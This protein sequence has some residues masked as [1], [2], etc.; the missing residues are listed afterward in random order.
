MEFL[1]AQNILSSNLPEFLNFI[2]IF[3][4]EFLVIIIFLVI[5]VF[6]TMYAERKIYSLFVY[7][8]IPHKARFSDSL[9]IIANS[10]KLIFQ[11]AVIPDKADKTGFVLAPVIALAPV[12]FVWTIIP[13]NTDFCICKFDGGV[14]LFFTMLM[15][16]SFGVLLGGRASENKFSLISALRCCLQVI[17]YEIPVLLSVMS[18]VILSGTL[19][20]PQTVIAQAKYDIFSWYIFPSFFG[21]LI[22]VISGLALVSM[23]PFGFSKR[24]SNLYSGYLAEYSGIYYAVFNLAEYALLFIVCVYASTLFLG[25]FLSPFGIYVADFFSNNGLYYIIL[26]TEQIFWL[27]SKTIV[28]ILLIFW[29]KTA[30]PLLKPDILASFAWKYLIPLSVINLLIVAVIKLAFG[31]IYV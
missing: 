20:L 27:L 22:F 31:G 11:D 6:I 3:A 10:V 19:S 13:F 16:F 12:I 1:I 2:L 25:G 24:E 4:A 29:V 21:F 30:L 15:I 14:I 28:L 26:T 23:T 7:N 9:R 8:K 18:V 17:S 5:S